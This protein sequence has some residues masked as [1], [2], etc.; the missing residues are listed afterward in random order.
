MVDI[1]KKLNV[2]TDAFLK[3]YARWIPRM[4]KWSLIEKSFGEDFHCV[5]LENGK[6]CS[7]YEVRPIQCRTY[8][9]WPSVMESQKTWNEE[10]QL[11]EGIDSESAPIEPLEKI[12]RT[13]EVQGEDTERTYEVGKRP[14]FELSGPTEQSASSELQSVSSS[15]IFLNK[16]IPKL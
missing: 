10:K 13:L 12:L 3:K 15:K 6:L 14:R 1:S 4:G 7:I 8:P 11:C 5:F 9:Y 16:T 2:E